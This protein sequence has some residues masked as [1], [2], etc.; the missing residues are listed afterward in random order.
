MSGR[1]AMGFIESVGL[2]AAITAADAALKAANVELVGRENSRGSGYI[3]I[4][5]VGDVGAVKAAIDVAKGVSSNVARVWSTDVIPRPAEDLGRL[6][7]WNRE[8]QGAEEWLNSKTSD[9]PL[10]N[11]PAHEM[12][13]VKEDIP[14]PAIPQAGIIE[15]TGAGK[16]EEADDLPVADAEP[17]EVE[18]SPAGPAKAEGIAREPESGDGEDGA[19]DKK[20][21]NPPKRGPSRRKSGG[22]GRKPK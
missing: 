2:A 20:G 7:V 22:R 4:K 16:P 11:P 21:P 18:E 14:K 1:K 15:Q 6:M 3:T 8:T 5:I 19:P 9:S 13:P 10:A 12:V 17:D